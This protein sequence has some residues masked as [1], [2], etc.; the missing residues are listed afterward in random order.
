MKTTEKLV[1][2]KNADFKNWILEMEEKINEKSKKLKGFRNENI[3][4]LWNEKRDK[5]N[6]RKI[7][8]NWK[9]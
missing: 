8:K 5:S 4:K 3:L 9:Q 1:Y 7:L 6:N 2:E